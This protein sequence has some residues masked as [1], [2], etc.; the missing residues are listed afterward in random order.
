MPMAE[1]AIRPNLLQQ[2]GGPFGAPTVAATA[3]APGMIAAHAQLQ[4]ASLRSPY[5]FGPPSAM[6]PNAMP[7][8]V[9]AGT[10]TWAAPSAVSQLGVPS[11][12]NPWPSGSA[13]GHQHGYQPP[14]AAWPTGLPSA[15]PV[16]S[17][18]QQQHAPTVTSH[19]LGMDEPLANLVMAWYW[20]GY[21]TGHYAACQG[22]AR[23]N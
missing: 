5:S 3:A 7:P 6:P 13:L 8:P 9:A 20:S 22:R 21:Y 19:T 23:G 10:S 2:L 17:S 1:A 18:L 15:T 12:A 16:A 14:A 4:A 11:W